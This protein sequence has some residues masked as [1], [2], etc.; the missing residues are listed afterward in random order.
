MFFSFEIYAVNPKNIIMQFFFCMI[1]G[2][3]RFCQKIII[4]LS[5]LFPAILL[6]F[7]NIGLLLLCK[8]GPEFHRFMC[9]SV[10]PH[11]VLEFSFVIQSPQALY[12]LKK[13]WTPAYIKLGGQ[14][15]SS[16]PDACVRAHMKIGIFKK[17]Y[18]I[19]LGKMNS[20]YFLTVLHKWPEWWE[21]KGEL[22]G[23]LYGCVWMGL[24]PPNSSFF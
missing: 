3:C 9:I 19:E 16:E 7:F 15:F 23:L 2:P 10:F 24:D 5:N 6:Y 4:S 22:P 18:N 8:F 17:S 14:H 11:L 13:F 1:I 12:S 21:N 20:K